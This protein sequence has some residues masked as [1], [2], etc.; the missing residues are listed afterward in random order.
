MYICICNAVTDKDI[1]HAV[2]NGATRMRDLRHQLGVAS[3]CACCAQSARC[4]L[5][6]SLAQ[7]SRTRTW[8][9]AVIHALTTLPEPELEAS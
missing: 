2:A 6:T 3:D 7:H 1:E 8:A 4:C 5:Q 9:G